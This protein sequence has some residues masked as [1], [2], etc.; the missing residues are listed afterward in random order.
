MDPLEAPTSCSSRYT[1]THG[2]YTCPSPAQ[3]PCPNLCPPPCDPC[4]LMQVYSG[5]EYNLYEHA[6]INSGGG[7]QLERRQ[8]LLGL[9]SKKKCEA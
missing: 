4:V 1:C 2:S 6:P 9:F 8:V 5:G 7:A 3:K